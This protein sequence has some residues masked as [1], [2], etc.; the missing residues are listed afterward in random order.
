MGVLKTLTDEYFDKTLRKEEGKFLDVCGCRVIVPEDY[1]EKK[2]FKKIE[3]IMKKTSIFFCKEGENQ[4]LTFHRRIKF[5]NNFEILI[6]D[7][8]LVKDDSEDIRLNIDETFYK[9]YMKFI[10]HIVQHIDL[11]KYKEKFCILL[12]SK[13]ETGAVYDEIFGELGFLFGE[14]EDF[15]EY[16]APVLVQFFN[17]YE[18]KADIIRAEIEYIGLNIAM[19]IRNESAEI[20]FKTLLFAREM[21][22]WWRMIL[23]EIEKVGLDEYVKKL[24][25]VQVSS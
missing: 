4:Y 25:R 8:S 16:F 5:H 21:R 10:E 6:P 9:S 19:E 18:S 14:T 22:A 3:E 11:I 7:F 2:F 23:K 17:E 13:E 24:Q 12:A 1:N 15:A 20:Q